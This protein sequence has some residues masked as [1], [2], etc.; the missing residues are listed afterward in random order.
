M[1]DN[2]RKRPGAKDASITNGKQR[3]KRESQAQQVS[4]KMLKHQ[5]KERKKSV[6]NS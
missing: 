5:S 6:K 3:Q 2:L 1:M 4:Q